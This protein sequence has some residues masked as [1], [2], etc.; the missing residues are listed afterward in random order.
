M[1]C[2]PPLFTCKYLLG[3]WGNPAASWVQGIQQ[4]INPQGPALVQVKALRWE[5]WGAPG[6]QIQVGNKALRRIRK[7]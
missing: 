2:A 1:Q 7:K 4:T 5:D 3:M 6:K